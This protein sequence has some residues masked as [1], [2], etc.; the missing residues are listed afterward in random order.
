QRINYLQ[1][2][3]ERSGP[4][5]S[6]DDRQGMR[7]LRA[8]VNEMDIY[9]VDG[10]DELRQGVY[11]RF[12]LAPVVVCLPIVGKLAHGRELYTLRCIPHQ[13][14]GGPFRCGDPSM[15]VRERVIGGV[16]LERA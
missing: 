9:P 8:N 1:L 12:D 3:D 11:P 7:M 16:K 10:S 13:F 15:Q 4:P 5:M 14:G 2:F 6:H